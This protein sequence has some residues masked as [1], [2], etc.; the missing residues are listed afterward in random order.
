MTATVPVD[1][2][3][4][5]LG[6]RRRLQAAMRAKGVD[7][8]LLFNEPNIRY[9]SGATAMPVYAMSTFVRCAVVALEGDPILFEHPSS[10]YR[11][12]TRA[13][14]VRPMH[15][16]EFYDDPGAEESVWADETV[17]AL[18]ELGVDETSAPVA[19]DRL[20]TPALIAL[21]ARGVRLR[22]SA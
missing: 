12:R 6:R 10:V 16:W 5:R 1:L 11:S 2:D 3:V 7:A 17:A 14:D 21:Q 19:V 15:A 20:G 9:A 18:R 13:V 8:C 4:L 22:D